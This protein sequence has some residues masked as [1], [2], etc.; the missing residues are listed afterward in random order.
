MTMAINN[1]YI[2]LI[3]KGWSLENT[4]SKFQ[5]TNIKIKV[6]CDKLQCKHISWK[7]STWQKITPGTAYIT[8][9]KLKFYSCVCSGGARALKLGGGQSRA[10]G[11][12]YLGGSRCMLPLENFE[13]GN[14]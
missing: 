6:L 9:W 8:D 13:I 10:V 11:V 12:S 3:Q 5:N 14:P 2:Q 1:V 7:Y 4:K